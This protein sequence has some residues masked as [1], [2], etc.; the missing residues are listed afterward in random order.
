MPNQHQNTP[1]SAPK[2][3]QK[4]GQ[5][6]SGQHAQQR[7][8]DHTNSARAGEDLTRPDDDPSDAGGQRGPGQQSRSGQ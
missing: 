4:S 2:E 6:K 8:D 3:G 7:S 1:K 5:Q